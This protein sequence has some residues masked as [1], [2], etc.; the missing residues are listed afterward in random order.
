MIMSKEKILKIIKILILLISIVLVL[1]LVKKILNKEN[2]PFITDTKSYIVLSGSMEPEINVGDIVIV[3]KAKQEEIRVGDIVSFTS[4]NVMVT[5]RIVEIADNNGKIEYTT[6]GD[7]NN[8]EDLRTITYQDIVGKYNYKIPKIGYAIL[9]IQQN[10]LLV[11]LVF[12]FLIVF[13]VTKPKR[14]EKIPNDSQ[15]N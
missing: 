2:I 14:D 8:T 6:K 3:K 5:H 9:F 4:G 13:I 11:I 7:N 12:V 10:L 15:K 1:I